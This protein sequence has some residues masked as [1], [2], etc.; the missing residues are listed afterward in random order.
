METTSKTIQTERMRAAEAASAAR[1]VL[2]RWS[3]SGG[4]AAQH[5]T[6]ATAAEIVEDLLVFL[7][8]EGFVVVQTSPPRP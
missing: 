1:D 6:G 4:F 2:L 5:N 3:E 7:A 8:R